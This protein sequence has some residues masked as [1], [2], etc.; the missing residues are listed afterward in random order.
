ME[1][2]AKNTSQNNTVTTEEVQDLVLKLQKEM[3]HI[4][5]VYPNFA[6]LRLHLYQLLVGTITLNFKYGHFTEQ[7]LEAFGFDIYL[8]CNVL[9]LAEKINHSKTV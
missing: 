1:V 6:I 3:Q 4:G 2:V 5:T 9:E 7:E 8:I